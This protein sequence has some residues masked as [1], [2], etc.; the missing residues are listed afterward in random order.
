VTARDSDKDKV[1][2]AV[3]VREMRENLAA[4]IEFAQLDAKI[5]RAKY[6][7]LVTEGFSEAEALIL[8]KP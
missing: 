6:L 2:L 8:C 5:K 1:R 7:A 4:H 3:L